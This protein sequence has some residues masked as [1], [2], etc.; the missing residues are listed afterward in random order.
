MGH[1]SSIQI[2]WAARL[3]PVPKPLC[4]PAPLDTQKQEFAKLDP[5]FLYSKSWYLAGLLGA[6]REAVRS[7]VTVRLWQ[8][9][10][11][12]PHPH[13]TRHSRAPSSVCAAV[14][15]GPGPTELLA[16]H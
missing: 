13:L 11:E 14:L 1:G 5:A 12:Q 7:V 10:R 4:V 8:G 3:E 16:L 15:P 2:H 6:I 9:R